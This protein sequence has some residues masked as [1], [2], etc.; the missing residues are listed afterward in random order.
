MNSKGTILTLVLVFITI[1]SISGMAFL[2]ISSS[3]RIVAINEINRIKSF[4]LAEAGVERTVS[5]LVY[6]PGIPEVNYH[7][8]GQP[9]APFSGNQ[10]LGSGGGYYV[11]LVYPDMQ[12]Q[13]NPT[14]LYYI[15]SSTGTIGVFSKCINKRIRIRK[16]VPDAEQIYW[17]EFPTRRQ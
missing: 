1:L 13:H 2:Y 12:N 10:Y 17:K 16:N 6:Y 5:W 15:I 8:Y 14:N 3:Q 9:F 7:G 11:V 4:Y